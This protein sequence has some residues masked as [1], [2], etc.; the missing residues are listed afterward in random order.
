MHLC[1]WPRLAIGLL[2]ALSGNALIAQVDSVNQI[3]DFERQ[4]VTLTCF[5]GS[6][7]RS[8]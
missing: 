3:G 7:T 2:A 5:M 1:V 4:L 6:L 8:G